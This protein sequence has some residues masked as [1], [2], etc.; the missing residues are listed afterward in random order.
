MLAKLREL[1]RAAGRL[2][3]P[4]EPRAPG[5]A[6]RSIA[7]PPSRLGVQAQA[8]DDTLY[9]A[10]GQR[11]VSTIFTQLNQYH[12]VL[13]VAPRFQESPDALD[14]SLRAVDHRRRQV[15]LSAFTRYAPANTSLAV[16][17]QSQFPAVTLSFNLAPGVALGDAVDRHPGGR[18]PG[19]AARLDPTD[20]PGHRAGLPGS[21]WPTSRS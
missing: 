3:R 18:A 11:Q 13:E 12:V 6:R 5:H 14:R 7:T 15:P 16:S 20:V 1:A 8:V 17:H 9:N 2:H 4:A 19:G 10:F 21:R